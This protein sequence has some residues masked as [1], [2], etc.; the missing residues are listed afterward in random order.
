[1]IMVAVDLEEREEIKIEMRV[2][3]KAALYLQQE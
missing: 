2:Y 3:K 1:M